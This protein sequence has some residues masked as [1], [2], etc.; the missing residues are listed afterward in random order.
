MFS[1]S[2]TPTEVIVGVGVDFV[3]KLATGE[4][5]ESYSVV[6]SPVVADVW[7]D[8]T[9]VLVTLAGGIDGQEYTVDFDI[10][11][12]LGTVSSGQIVVSIVSEDQLCTVY[13]DLK[14]PSK[15]PA[16]GVRMTGKCKYATVIGGEIISDDQVSMVTDATGHAEITVPQGAIIEVYF[17]P[18]GQKV[19]FDTTGHTLINLADVVSGTI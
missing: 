9:K 8:G 18:L 3:E 16:S 7:V 13:V 10:L 5:I 2:K 12:T 4:A 14:T 17:P 1:F 15:L 6:G 11:G 19:S